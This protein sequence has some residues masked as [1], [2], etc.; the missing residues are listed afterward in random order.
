MWLSNL[1]TIDI[2]SLAPSHLKFGAVM[3]LQ[4]SPLIPM[5]LCNSLPPGFSVLEKTL[6]F[7]NLND[8]FL[9]SVSH[10]SVVAVLPAPDAGLLGGFLS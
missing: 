10:S 6:G 1:I 3:T 5:L 4:M 9:L 2:V 7:K 8:Y